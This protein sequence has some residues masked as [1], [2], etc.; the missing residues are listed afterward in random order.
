MALTRAYFIVDGSD[1]LTHVGYWQKASPVVCCRGV[2]GIDC[3][4]LLGLQTFQLLA[5]LICSLVLVA[6][7]WS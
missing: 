5:Y 4:T 6:A 1:L 3:N 7:S 2:I